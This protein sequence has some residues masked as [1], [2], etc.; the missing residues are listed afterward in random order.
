MVS[1]QYL[2]YFVKV[3]QT[4]SMNKAAEELFISQ[5]A[6]SLAMKNLEN[7]LK[8][9]LFF[10]SNKG[11]ELTE[12]GERLLK[13]ARLV[14]DQCALIESMSE[15]E[16]EKV[17]SVSGFPCLIPAEVM[18]EYK[19]EDGYGSSCI[20]FQECR[21]GEILENV[22]DSISEIGVIQYNNHQVTAL[23]RKIK[24]MNLEMVDICTVPWAVVVGKNS[25]LYDRES[26]DMEELRNYRLIRSKDDYFSYITS[27]IRVNDMRMDDLEYDRIGSGMM[28]SALLENTDMFL[29][30]ARQK[31]FMNITSKIHIIP[32]KET[33]VEIHIGWIKKQKAPLSKEASFFI[34]LLEKEF[35]NEP[36]N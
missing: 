35:N 24:N 23:K 31:H 9:T 28:I 27:E 34:S 20:D 5:P 22:R 21:V 25:P 30:A 32:L 14:I 11:I 1:L 16:E 2:N 4:R 12:E 26:V 33:P 19:R 6:L 29:F 10:R 15:K 36:E 3:C 7:E 13:H 8:I 18:L 17:L